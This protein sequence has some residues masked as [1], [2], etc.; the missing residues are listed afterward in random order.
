MLREAI[1]KLMLRSTR[2]ILTFVVLL[3]CFA[4][5]WLWLT[6][7]AAPSSSGGQGVPKAWNE[8]AASGSPG[9]GASGE[10]RQIGTVTAKK[11]AEISG[12]TASRTSPGLWWVHNDSG[13]RA[14]LYVID[15]S[16]KLLGSF[17]VTGAKN[18][19][20][21]DIASGPGADGNPAL[22]LADI[23]NNERKRDDLVIYRVKEPDLSKGVVSGATN[24]AEAF[25][26]RY[27]DGQHDAEAMF[28]N[29]Q[30]GRIYIVTKT[31]RDPCAIY[32]FPLP[33]RAGQRVTLEIVKGDAT[34]AIS[35]LRMV[36]GG[37]ASGDGRRVVIRT[38]FTAMELTRAENQPFDALFNAEPKSIGI[39]LERQGEAIAYT[40]DGKSIVTTSEQLPAPIYQITFAGRD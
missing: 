33:L 17:D 16:G 18:R 21:E 25:F 12:I 14:R 35:R 9:V 28:V 38:Y 13:D 24:P 10:S 29:P 2:L 36:T 4:G 27:P 3:L 6:Q 7:T 34:G 39:P 32:R 20:W 8:I 31:G 23:G 40:L 1:I 26:F 5:L 30:D 37:A 19:D 15:S 22:Y 11:L